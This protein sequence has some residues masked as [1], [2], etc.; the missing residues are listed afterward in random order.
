M[1]VVPRRFNLCELQAAVDTAQAE[2]PDVVELAFGGIFDAHFGERLCIYVVLRENT[3]TSLSWVCS[4]PEARGLAKTKWP[5][6]IVVIETL[7]RNALNKVV[8]A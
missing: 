3:T 4:F 2:F 6:K 8:R 7:P 1:G 5:E